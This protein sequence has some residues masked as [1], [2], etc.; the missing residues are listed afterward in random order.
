MTLCLCAKGGPSAFAECRSAVQKALDNELV[1][2]RGYQ[3]TA[4]AVRQHLGA[5]KRVMRQLFT[6]TR[7]S[8]RSWRPDPAR[9]TKTEDGQ[10]GVTALCQLHTS[11]ASVDHISSSHVLATGTSIA[12]TDGAVWA[13]DSLHGR[14]VSID[15]I[16][17]VV[18]ATLAVRGQPAGVAIAPDG[19]VWT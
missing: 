19:A 4:V 16:S 1:H 8:Q 17:G 6:S 12:A 7:A 11:Y 3:Q 15:P 14:V 18:L 2:R 5:R 10:P 13:T 9:T